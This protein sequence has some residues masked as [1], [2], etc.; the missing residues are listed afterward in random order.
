MAEWAL[1][2]S[3][4]FWVGLL[5][6]FFFIL[7]KICLIYH[8]LTTTEDTGFLGTKEADSFIMDLNK[9]RDNFH[10]DSIKL[11]ERKENAP[12]RDFLQT[13]IP[14]TL[15]WKDRGLNQFF[16]KYIKPNRNGLSSRGFLE[17][18]NQILSILDRYGNCPSIVQKDRKS[19]Q[20]VNNEI[21]SNG[22]GALSKISLLEHSLNTAAI[23]IE[24]RKTGNIDYKE[25]MGVMLIAGLGHDL[26]KIPRF[27][28]GGYKTIDHPFISQKI[29]SG[30]LPDKLNSRDMILTAV[31]DHHFPSRGENGLTAILKSADHKARAKEIQEDAGESGSMLKEPDEKRKDAQNENNE[32]RKKGNHQYEH[33]DLNWL[34][35]RHL[36][37]KLSSYINVIKNSKEYRAFSVI[38]DGLV[39]IQPGLIFEVVTNLGIE[40]GMVDLIAHGAGRVHKNDVA[41]AARRLLD[42]YIPEYVGKN[43]IGQR[44]SIITKKGDTLS[45]PGFYLP[46]RISAFNIPPS[47]LEERKKGTTYG[48]MTLQSIKRLEVYEKTLKP[49]SLDIDGVLHPL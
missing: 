28:P 27:S 24:D 19:L 41:H 8:G 36:L 14:D 11:R 42:K 13:A 44:Y 16:L 18:L 34:D 2:I 20:R 25:M 23:L 5:T 15:R 32:G 45:K 7:V 3:A 26:G 35:P 49:N 38:G 4:L 29:L 6:C 30:I 43:F 10:I 33:I 31:R 48:H 47:K 1:D 17:P 37:D 40:K 21:D 22:F 9:K 39:Y 12:G 46:I